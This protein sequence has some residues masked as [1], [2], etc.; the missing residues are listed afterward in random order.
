MDSR[1]VWPQQTDSEEEELSRLLRPSR[2]LPGELEN[3]YS[4]MRSQ[5]GALLEC[6]DRN[7]PSSAMTTS[8]VSSISTSASFSNPITSSD[9]TSLFGPN[10][11]S[12]FE[13]SP[14][15]RNIIPAVSEPR[16]VTLPS[17]LA[18]ATCPSSYMPSPWQGSSLN[19]S[20]QASTNQ[21]LTS[22]SLNDPAYALTD[23]PVAKLAPTAPNMYPQPPSTNLL[24]PTQSGNDQRLALR[25]QPSPRSE[26]KSPNMQLL[27]C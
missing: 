17:S 6:R 25:D 21:L 16:Q 8:S 4:N 5:C 13:S 23:C 14:E 27:Q 9:L 11:L 20:A 3:L 18:M 26:R 19:P 24:V 22:Q 10:L 1:Q 15:S 12:L 2:L 7:I